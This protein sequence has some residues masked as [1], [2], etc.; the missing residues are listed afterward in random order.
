MTNAK[1]ASTTK[2]DTLCNLKMYQEPTG[3]LN[4]LS[5]FTRPDIAFAI[6]KLSKFHANPTNTNF[7]AAL[8]VLRYLKFTRNY[9]IVYGR[10]ST[11]PI[12]DIIGYSDAHKFPQQLALF[13]SLPKVKRRSRLI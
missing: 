6:S 9:R 8:H 11:V 1:S 12:T 13:L 2:Y 4:H 5:V 10:S 3:F 7:K